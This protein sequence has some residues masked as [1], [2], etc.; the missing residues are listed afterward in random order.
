MNALVE[1]LKDNGAKTI[2]TV[3]ADDLFG[4]QTY[5]ALEVAVSGSRLSPAEEKSCPA[6]VKDPGPVLRG[7]K[8]KNPDVFVSLSYPPDTILAS[9]QSKEIGFNPKFFYA[10]VGTAFP[11]YKQVMGTASDGVGARLE[12]GHAQRGRLQAVQRARARPLQAALRP[13]P[14]CARAVR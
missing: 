4:L 1:L 2:A 11:L 5:A 9:R 14:S 12:R 6:G 8:D 13:A 7:I 10:G 3:Y